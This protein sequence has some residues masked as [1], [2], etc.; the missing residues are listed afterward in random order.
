M[1]GLAGFNS[2]RYN[3]KV[4]GL[5]WLRCRQG[6][7]SIRYNL[8]PENDQQKEIATFSFNS[9]RYNLKIIAVA[10]AVLGAIGFQ[11]HKVQFK[12]P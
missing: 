2:I 3:L 8:K 11:F 1:Q 6:F 10:S 4:D 5:R 7:N 12:V 9:I